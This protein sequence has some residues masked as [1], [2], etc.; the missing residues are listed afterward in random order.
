VHHDLCNDPF[1]LYGKSKCARL[2]FS[3]LT[4]ARALCHHGTLIQRCTANCMETRKENATAAPVQT[5]VPE[6]DTIWQ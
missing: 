3:R 5:I 6:F 1:S 4:M 2:Q